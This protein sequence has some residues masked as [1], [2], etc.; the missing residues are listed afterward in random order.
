MCRHTTI[1][2]SS[3]YYICLLILAASTVVSIDELSA[4]ARDSD[5]YRCVL[6]LY[7]HVLILLYMCPHTTVLSIEEFA[8]A[9]ESRLLNTTLHNITQQ[10][11]LKRL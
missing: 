1:H 7:I 5:D 9:S 10:V 11:P 2:V 6:I 4:E 3:Y 8:D